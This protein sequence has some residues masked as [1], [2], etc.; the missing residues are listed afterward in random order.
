MMGKKMRVSEVQH[1]L[2]TQL[3]AKKTYLRWDYHLHY[4]IHGSEEGPGV[5]QA[6]A[7]SLLKKGLLEIGQ[8]PGYL[9]LP[10]NFEY[11]FGGVVYL[12]T[13]EFGF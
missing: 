10:D 3:H 12:M 8:E 1:K 4:A 5:T 6:T 9:K 11:Q 7:I 2:L 13:A